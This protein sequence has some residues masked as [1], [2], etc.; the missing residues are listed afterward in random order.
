MG[1][2][3]KLDSEVQFPPWIPAERW[4][5]ATVVFAG[6]GTVAQKGGVFI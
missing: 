5:L 3:V 1:L 6:I 4:M 2:G